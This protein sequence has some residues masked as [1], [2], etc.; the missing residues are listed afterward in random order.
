[1]SKGG[2]RPRTRTRTMKT[3]PGF[4]PG[5]WVDEHFRTSSLMRAERGERREADEKTTLL[6]D[7]RCSEA[8]L[9]MSV[10]CGEGARE[11]GAKSR[12]NRHISDGQNTQTLCKLSV[13]RR[14]R[15]KVA[16]SKAR[17]CARRNWDARAPRAA[18]AR[19]RGARD[20]QADR[21]ISK[22][23][24]AGILSSSSLSTQ[25]NGNRS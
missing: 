24:G 1:M 9:V 4:E 2:A 7:E 10:T 5:P 12:R 21:I 8:P 15:R 23:L 13:R 11:H 20:R 25:N 17:A 16:R 14:R 18:E 6:I 19:E 22:R 3:R